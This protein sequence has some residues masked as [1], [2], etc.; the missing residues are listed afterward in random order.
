[1][2]RRTVVLLGLITGLSL[3]PSHPLGAQD[4]PGWQAELFGASLHLYDDG[5]E[6]SDQGYGL[7]GAYRFT[8]RWAVEAALYKVNE[9]EV[10]IFVGD[11]SAKVTLADLTSFSLYAVAGPG[12]VRIAVDD[13]DVDEETYHLGLGAEIPLGAKGYLRPDVRGRRYVDSDID[14]TLVDY[15]LGFG[16][17]F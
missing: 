9:D 11:L 1:M 2:F 10:D 12:L 13:F 4:E 6:A 16:W 7:R 5:D 8:S 17:K 3:F 14:V 15:S